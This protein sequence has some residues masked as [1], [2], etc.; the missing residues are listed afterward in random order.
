MLGVSVHP[1]FLVAGIKYSNHK[2]IK[3]SGFAASCFWIGN[4]DSSFLEEHIS[5]RTSDGSLQRSPP[6]L[7]ATHRA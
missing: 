7:V 3:T 1:L 4:S 2:D 5:G 6:E